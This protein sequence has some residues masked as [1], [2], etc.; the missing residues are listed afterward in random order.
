VQLVE[1]SDPIHPMIGEMQTLP[2]EIKK[3]TYLYHYG[4]N[5]DEGPYDFVNEEFA[6]FTPPQQRI[7]LFE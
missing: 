4:D 3:R 2:D 5:W 7:R 1:Q 6:G